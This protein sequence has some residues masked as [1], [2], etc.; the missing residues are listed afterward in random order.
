MVIGWMRQYVSSFSHR[1]YYNGGTLFLPP[2]RFGSEWG[3]VVQ[4]AI[5][6]DVEDCMR[7]VRSLLSHSARKKN[8]FKILISRFGRV[9][10][11]K[12]VFEIR[13][14]GKLGAMEAIVSCRA[15]LVQCLEA[16]PLASRLAQF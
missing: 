6:R 1:D 3:R 14:L 10:I 15:A 12:D 5:C 13:W 2:C 8:D 7:C 4:I 9:I 16:L 11:P